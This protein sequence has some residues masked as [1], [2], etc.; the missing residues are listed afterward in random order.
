LKTVLH[1]WEDRTR[2]NRQITAQGVLVKYWGNLYEESDCLLQE[3]MISLG[4]QLLELY[5][6]FEASVGVS[7]NR[8][9]GRGDE[10][11]PCCLP[12]PGGSQVLLLSCSLW[13][14]LCFW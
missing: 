10:S 1:I 14:S 8:R 4:K 2:N 13:G 3:F 6:L 7:S 5:D 9:K 11:I 12:G